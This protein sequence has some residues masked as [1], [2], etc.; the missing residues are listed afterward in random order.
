ME[1]TGGVVDV[2]EGVGVGVGV[3]DGVVLGGVDE[4]VD[5]MLSI[6]EEMELGVIEVLLVTGG[7]LLLA[8]ELDDGIEVLVG[9]GDA[10][11][12]VVGSPGSVLVELVDIVNCLSNTSFLGRLYI[13][14]SAKRNSIMVCGHHVY[15]GEQHL[16]ASYLKQGLTCATATQRVWCW[17][18]K[19]RCFV[20][21]K[22]VGRA[23]G[24]RAASLSLVG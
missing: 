11:V 23:P 15:V 12:D 13:A 20:S 10:W 18:Q 8:I 24:D 22:S 1:D 2:V 7:G 16:C 19:R 17:T 9:D 6:V 14:M 4:G 5:E 21:G 3:D